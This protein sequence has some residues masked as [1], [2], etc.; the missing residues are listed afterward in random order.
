MSTVGVPLKL[1]D[2][3]PDFESLVLQL[4]LFLDSKGT[5]SDV[6]PS[7]LG[8]TL[9]EMMAAVGAFNQ[10]AIESA[11][12]EAFLSTAKRQ[13]SVYAVA[14]MLGVRLV[15]KSPASVSVN[16]QRGD[17]TVQ[18]VISKFTQF[19]I[20]NKKFFNRDNI[21]FPAGV[22]AVGK[23][24]IYDSTVPDVLLYEGEVK[25]K[26][27]S[28]DTTQFREIYL[29]EN[30][31]NVSDED[32]QVK[33]TNVI[34]NVNEVWSRTRNGNAIWTADPGEKVYYDSTSGLGDTIITFGDGSRGA[35]PPLGSSIDITYA[36]T[37][38]SAGNFGTSNI[39]VKSV[40]DG[41]ITGSTVEIIKGGSDEK[42]AMFYKTMV[43]HIFK[44]RSRAVTG[45]DYQAICL[46]Y[47]GIA[48]A[49]VSAQRTTAFRAST[50]NWMNVVQICLLPEKPL[51]AA[52]I[53]PSEDFT[54]TAGQKSDF[55]EYLQEFQH[56]AI[57]V[58]LKD[59]YKILVS[60]EVTVF[61][62]KAASPGLVLPVV[63]DR[64]RT[65]F[66]RSH[67]TLGRKI[68]QS[69]V[70]D[71]CLVEEVD[72]VD[73]K[74]MKFSDQPGSVVSDLLPL[75][76][77]VTDPTASFELR[78]MSAFLEL[79]DTPATFKINTQYSERG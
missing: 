18:K 28:S 46:H 40:A 68:A 58:D 36:I 23:A 32:V 41:D 37:S 17:S 19:T 61:L 2:T 72:Y 45:K 35:V 24:H 76:P 3:S 9:I 42:S 10:F 16:L 79:E 60:L 33:I 47:A 57:L 78:S 69:D 8:Q 52:G 25:T 26:S 71:A 73:L 49:T 56:V 62:K 14:R 66:A 29:E 51:P 1:S 4:Q 74:T 27:Y 34:Q 12:R 77:T 30:G 11:L 64:I 5:W 75:D 31:F 7:S 21:V 59:A 54:L 13:S 44:A 63:A 20:N 67:L 43:P 50:P 15:R 65:L 53:D 39:E 22:I 48:S 55:M 6:L 70:V 38:G